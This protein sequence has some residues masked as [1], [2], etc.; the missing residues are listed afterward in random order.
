M[1]YGYP[2]WAV[3]QLF[4]AVPRNFDWTERCIA[5]THLEIEEI[6]RL[7]KDGTSIEFGRDKEHLG[8]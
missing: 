3:N 5:I 1:I 2:N 8:K 7:V 6:Y 4:D